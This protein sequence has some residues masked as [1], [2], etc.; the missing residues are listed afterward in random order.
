LDRALANPGWCRKFLEAEVQVLPVCGP[1][2]QQGLAG[3]DL[4]SNLRLVGI[5]KLNVQMLF[6]KLGM[7]GGG[8]V[9]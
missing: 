8:L 6:V 4:L 2:L 7:E 1:Q 3:E 5:W 9:S